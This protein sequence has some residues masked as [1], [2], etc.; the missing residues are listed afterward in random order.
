APGETSKRINVLVTDDAVAEGDEQIN[1]SL[2]NPGSGCTLGEAATAIVTVTD[3]DAV[4]ATLNP[5]NDD[6]F[7][8]R[9]HYHDFLNREPDAAGLNFWIGQL[10]ECGA[11]ARCREAKRVN[12]SAAFF[13][14]IEFQQT[15]YFVERL[16]KSA[17]GRRPA[18]VEFMPDT[19][20][21]S[22][23]LVVGAEGWQDKLE[24]NKRAFV[25]QW[26]ARPAF[27]AE[28]DALTNE[29]FV[30]RLLTNAGI[31]A[32]GAERDDLARSLDEQRETRAGVV[33]R[34]AEN[35]DFA[36]REFNPAFVMMQY[37]GYLRRDPDEGGFNFWLS[38]LEQF[39]GNFVNAEM[40]KAFISSDEYGQRFGS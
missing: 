14:S 27:R 29:Q 18:L 8:V 23:D 1:L 33:R 25:E 21:A 40:V 30:D 32:S 19:Q 15:G 2:A 35:A 11:D 16:Y 26:V 12:V 3:N 13:L 20:E 6:A 31:P 4:T 10:N 17:Y 5:S 7:F 28:F 38:K 24:A 34:I 22:R 39:G 37:F 36:K 9:E